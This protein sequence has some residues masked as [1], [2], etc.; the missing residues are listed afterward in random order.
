MGQVIPFRR[1]APV[2]CDPFTFSILFWMSCASLMLSP[3]QVS[4]HVVVRYTRT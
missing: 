4:S 1:R 3:W 2:V